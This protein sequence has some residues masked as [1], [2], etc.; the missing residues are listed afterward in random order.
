MTELE[1]NGQ[2]LKY[3]IALTCLN[4][5]GGNP[6]P[7]FQYLISVTDWQRRYWIVDNIVYTSTGTSYCLFL[8]RLLLLF[9]LRQSTRDSVHHIFP[10][11]L[12]IL[13]FTTV[14]SATQG[15]TSSI[16]QVAPYYQ[17]T[18][19]LTSANSMGTSTAAPSCGTGSSGESGIIAYQSSILLI[20][21]V[22]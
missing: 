19:C 5:P 20:A 22:Q 17:F 16:V 14:A 13:C 12:F 4:C 9:L 11:T 21:L 7:T 1:Q 3:Q 2:D 6:P 10:F 15:S 18:A 8:P